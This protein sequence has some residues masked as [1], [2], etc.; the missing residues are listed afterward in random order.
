[1]QWRNSQEY[2]SICAERKADCDRLLRIGEDFL[3]TPHVEAHIRSSVQKFTYASGGNIHRGPHCPSPVL[4]LLI[5]KLRRGRLLKRVTALSKVTH[6]FGLNASG[7]FV[8]C[9]EMSDNQ[10]RGTE[11]L[12][13]LDTCRYGV[14]INEDRE[15][16]AV[17]EEIFQ[18]GKIVQYKYLT[19]YPDEEG[20]F[21][22]DLHAEKYCY[23]EQGLCYSEKEYFEP[24]IDSFQR[25]CYY[26]K[27]ENGYLAGYSASEFVGK[28]NEELRSPIDYYISKK[29]KA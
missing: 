15:L 18:D 12:F 26:F 13:E 19:V 25:R 14:A 20:Y 23:D 22:A 17:S 29:R 2:R 3:R 9:V 27:R 16:L 8:M 7:S 11:Y 6:R 24:Y 4:D 10:V 28:A 5:G 21:C 1:M